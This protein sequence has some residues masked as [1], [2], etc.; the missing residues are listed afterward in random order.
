MNHLNANAPFGII[1]LLRS[2]DF[3]KTNIS[4]HVTRAC[5]YQGVRNVTFSEN[6]VNV[7]N[8]WYLFIPTENIRKPKRQ[9]A[10]DF[11]SGRYVVHCGICYD[12]YNLKNVKNNFFISFLKGVIRSFLYKHNVFKVSLGMDVL[13]KIEYLVAVLRSDETLH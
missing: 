8:G 13:S 2:Q 11:L 9:T 5:T 12:L 6:V 10:A 1:H 4:Y 7:L 3:L